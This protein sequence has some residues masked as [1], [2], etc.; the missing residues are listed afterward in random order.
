MSV[1]EAVRVAQSNNFMGLICSSRLLVRRKVFF[2]LS[3]SW[4]DSYLFSIWFDWLMGLFFFRQNVAPALI[5]S[6]KVAGLVLVMNTSEE[7]ASSMSGAAV[8]SAAASRLLLCRMPDGVD[9][10]LQRNGILRFNETIDM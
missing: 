3:V 4:G 2:F 10:I 9:G 8:V 6:I 7:D 1:K 5:E